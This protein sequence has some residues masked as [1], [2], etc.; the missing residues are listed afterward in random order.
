MNAVEAPGLQTAGDTASMD[1]RG[2]EL[3]ECHDTVL[4]RSNA[5]DLGVPRN[6]GKF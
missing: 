3:R 2:L 5:C 1:A 6:L 4:T